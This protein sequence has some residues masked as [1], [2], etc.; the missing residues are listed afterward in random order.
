[1]KTQIETTIAVK[2]TAEISYRSKDM[3]T[4]GNPKKH[5]KKALFIAMEIEPLRKIEGETGTRSTM[6]RTIAS[7]CIYADEEAGY[8]IEMEIG[9][10]HV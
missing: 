8:C 7:E 5:A 10:A 4:Y 1:M 6:S 2:L 9:R 3:T